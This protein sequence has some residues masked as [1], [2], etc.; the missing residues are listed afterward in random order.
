MLVDINTEQDYQREQREQTPPVSPEL[1]AELTIQVRDAQIDERGVRLLECIEQGQSLKERS[2]RGALSYSN[3]WLTLNRMEEALGCK[4]RRASSAAQPAA[5]A[6]YHRR[7]LWIER[8]RRHRTPAERRPAPAAT[9]GIR[10]TRL[11]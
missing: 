5:A 3:A 6:A 11:T 10:Q 9:R 4:A 1:S 8:Y 7:P 2:A